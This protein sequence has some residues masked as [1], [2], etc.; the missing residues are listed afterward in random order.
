MTIEDAF[1]RVA[2]VSPIYQLMDL[3][4]QVKDDV[5]GRPV[6]RTYSFSETTHGAVRWLDFDQIARTFG[7]EPGDGRALLLSPSGPV[8]DLIRMA[9][10]SWLAVS[11]AEGMDS[12]GAHH[13]VRVRRW[14]REAPVIHDAAS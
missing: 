7:G 3:F 4:V 1:R 6:A 2:L 9:D 13:K 11:T 12:L 14:T 8:P 5:T 10:G